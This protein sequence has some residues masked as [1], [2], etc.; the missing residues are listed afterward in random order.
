MLLRLKRLIKYRLPDQRTEVRCNEIEMTTPSSND[1][2][3]AL[4][5]GAIDYGLTLSTEAIDVLVRYYEILQT[6]NPQLHLVAPTSPR[7]FATRHILESLLLINHLPQDAR[8]ADV[9]SGAGLPLI[10]CLIVRPDIQG[11]LIESSKKKSVFLREALNHT[12]TSDRAEVIAERFENVSLLDVAYVTSRAIERFEQ[13]LPQLFG[14]APARST[15][16]L[17]GGEQLGQRLK[18][19][20]AAV[21]TILIPKSKNRYLYIAR[22][23]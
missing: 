8:I 14:W 17:F 3:A 11:T 1:F 22:K 20:T 5:T 13:I 18:E 16:T 10:P 21:E 9:G 12:N 7:Q 6:W 23:D 15:L 2:R 4:K 19:L